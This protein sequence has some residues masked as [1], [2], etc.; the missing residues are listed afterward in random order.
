[1]NSKLK[2]LIAS[3][4]D[5]G[6]LAARPPKKVAEVAFPCDP[7]AVFEKQVTALVERL[8]RIHVTKVVIGISGGL[9]S[10]LCLLVAVEAFDRLNLPREQI[11]TVTMP[12]FGTSR[13]TKD[14]AVILCRGLGVSFQTI[15]IT[16]TC[17]QHLADIGHDGVT[18]DAAYEN[19]QARMRTMILMDLANMVGG[20]VLGTGDLSEIALGWC[21]YNGDHMSMFGVNSGVP[22]TIVRAV[23]AVRARQIDPRAGAALQDI[24]DTPVSPELIKGQVTEDRIGPYELHDFFLWNFIQN[25]LDG[26]DL[27]EAAQK[28]FG[29]KFSEAVIKKTLNT[30]LTRLVSQAF[31]RNCAP[32]GIRVFPFDLSPLGWR[33]PSDLPADLLT[34][35]D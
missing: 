35:D 4:R 17:R 10:A 18:P 16:T 9:D 27:L 8:S 15:D 24:I 34:L 14:N 29:T 5:V 19:A 33:I 11:Y 12:G 25:G 28:F 31:K 26:A 21:T 6:A 30:F 23:C 22:K 7:Q 20:I 2:E 32:D 13:R 3:G 1:M